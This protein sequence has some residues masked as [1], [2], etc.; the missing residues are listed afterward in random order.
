[1]KKSPFFFAALIA[2]AAPISLSAATVYWDGNDTV[3]GAG[4]TPTGTW[5]SSL[6][7]SPD[8]AGEAT[9]VGWTAGDAAVFSAGTD[10]I[11]AWNLNLNGTQV[12]SSV[13]VEEGNITVGTSGVIDT[14]TGTF[15]IGTGAGSTARVNIPSTLRLNSAG[16]VVLDGGTLFHTNTGNAGSFI[17][18]AKGLEIT[19]NGGSVGYDDSS[20]TNAFTTVYAGTITG[21]GGTTGN[22]GVG[23]LTKIGPDEFRYQGLGL[24]NTTYSKLLV[25]QGLFRLGFA[26]STQDERGFGAVPTVFTPDAIILAG[27]GSIGTSFTA[28]NS[29][30][31]ANRGITLGDGGGAINGSMTVPGAITGTG[32]FSHLTTGTVVLTGNSDYSG[33]TLI[34]LGIVVAGNANALGTTSGDTLFSR[35]PSF[36][37]TVRRALSR[38]MNPFRSLAAAAAA[39]VPSPSKTFPPR[40]SPAR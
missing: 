22:G 35:E 30:L 2:A 19:A 16:K 26:S 1:M 25:L 14:G 5:G 34:N 32:T 3:T 21:T 31:H 33:N 8:M 6:F 36:A 10:G 23:T 39:A 28:A 27:G 13:L 38:S 29:V 20:I 7:W 40:R 24:P 17:N 9:T 4:G 12:A 18:A 37:L 11:G 15:T